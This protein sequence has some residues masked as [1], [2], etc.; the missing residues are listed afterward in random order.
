MFQVL[1]Q[2][3]QQ[4]MKKKQQK[5]TQKLIDSGETVAESFSQGIRLSVALLVFV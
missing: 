5:R 4:K 2:Q 1:G 3:Q